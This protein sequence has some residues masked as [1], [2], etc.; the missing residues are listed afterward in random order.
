MLVIR[1]E[2]PV[3]GW[4]GMGAGMG[5]GW[6]FLILL[7]VGIVLLVMALVRGWSGGRGTPQAT[8]PSR[9]REILDQKYARGE[10]DTEE[11]HDRLQQLRE[12]A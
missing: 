8:G 9:A 4:Q 2:T 7:I 10:I 12:R 11:Y 1:M 3:G 6:L 5:W